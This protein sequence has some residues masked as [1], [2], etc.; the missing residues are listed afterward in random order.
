MRKESLQSTVE[1]IEVEGKLYAKKI[2]TEEGRQELI[3]QVE[4]FRALPDG[5]KI[6]YPKLVSVDLNSKPPFYTMDFY[7]YPTIR[8]LLID[9]DKTAP[10]INE[11]L[12][13]VLKF[14]IEKQHGWR[15]ADVPKGYVEKKYL[16]RA[17]SRLQHIKQKDPK[18]AKILDNT[19][20]YIADEECQNV[21]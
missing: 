9:T 12:S 4:L 15:T 14:L 6:H 16:E 10:F 1:Q 5:L 13:F 21:L 19:R 3:E 11:R 7:S 18:F 20:V 8:Q 2:A 17:Q